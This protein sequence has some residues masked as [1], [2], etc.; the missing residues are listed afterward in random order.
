MSAQIRHK[1]SVYHISEYGRLQTCCVGIDQEK[2]GV[3]GQK[4]CSEC[5]QGK[6][7][8]FN[9]PNLA[10]GAAPVG[11][12]VHDDAVIGAAPTNLTLYK[13]YA[14]VHQPADRCIR[15]I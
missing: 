12:R 1:S 9:L 8:L 13:F 15:E 5:D 6:D 2:Q 4:L 7:V 11:G 3:F 14:V 10:F